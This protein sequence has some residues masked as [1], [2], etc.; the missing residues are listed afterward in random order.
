MNFESREWKRH[1]PEA[2]AFCEAVK[3]S[4]GNPADALAEFGLRGFGDETWREAQRLM[5]KAIH[6]RK[7]GAAE[8]VLVADLATHGS[9]SLSQ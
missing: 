2:R 8:L 5:A 4:G 1:I 7:H 3:K 6:K 9:S